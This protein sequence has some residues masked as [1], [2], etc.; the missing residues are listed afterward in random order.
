MQKGDIL[1]EL[2]KDRGLS[3]A[4]IAVLLK[5]TR[6]YYSDYE[7]E[8]FELPLHHLEFLAD[9]FNVSS[10]YLLGRTRNPKPYPPREI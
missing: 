8:K 9:F 10:D 2:R 1:R 4:D 5:T 3:Q 6:Q 7:C